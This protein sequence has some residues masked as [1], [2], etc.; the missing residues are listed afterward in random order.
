MGFMEIFKMRSMNNMGKYLPTM[1]NENSRMQ[2][3]TYPTITKRQSPNRRKKKQRS[4]QVLGMGDQ[5]V[6]PICGK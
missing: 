3:Y 5:W 4:E 6:L 1:Q 2:K